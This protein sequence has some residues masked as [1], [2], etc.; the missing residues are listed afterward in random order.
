M[1]SSLRDFTIVQS[2]GR[3]SYG[4]VYKAT[5]KSDSLTYAVKEVNIRKLNA[6]E[7]SAP[8]DNDSLGATV[9]ISVLITP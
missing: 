5:R 6:R 3:G 9:S 2:L 7:R 8:A 1:A 4:S